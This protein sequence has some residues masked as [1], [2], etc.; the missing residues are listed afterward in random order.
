MLR[1]VRKRSSHPDQHQRRPGFRRRIL[2]DARCQLNPVELIVRAFVLS[3]DDLYHGA[4]AAFE[5]SPFL[6]RRTA[7]STRNSFVL[8]YT[9]L[10]H[11]PTT[12]FSEGEEEE[13]EAPKS[14]TS[15]SMLRCRSLLLFSS[16]C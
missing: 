6:Q 5:F 9:E 12:I 16:L 8:I 1:F 2:Q 7:D 3:S 14:A 11:S 15:Y 10:Q 4:A 13:E